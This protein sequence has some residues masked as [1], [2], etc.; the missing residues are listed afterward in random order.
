MFAEVVNTDLAAIAAS[1]IAALGGLQGIRTIIKRV[2]RLVEISEELEAKSKKLD[3]VC[4]TIEN[5][6]ARMVEF[7]KSI[8]AF[9]TL[10]NEMR[11][12]DAHLAAL[13]EASEYGVWISD[14]TGLCL[15]CNNALTS[16]MMASKDS[17]IGNSWRDIIHPEDRESVFSKWA[18]F[19]KGERTVFNMDYRY[20]SA[21]GKVVKV[22]GTAIRPVIKGVRSERIYGWA[23]EI[24]PADYHHEK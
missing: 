13:M 21:E 19:V 12:Q 14:S 18:D 24:K 10:E 6:S 2:G 5:H 20:Q 3:T 8:A 11:R 22:R 4:L 1:I 23:K 15:T 7:E 17:I 16:L 9:A